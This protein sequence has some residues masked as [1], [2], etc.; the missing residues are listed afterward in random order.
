MTVEEKLLKISYTG[1]YVNILPSHI[2][3]LIKPQMELNIFNIKKLEREMVG[4]MRNERK[5]LS[6]MFRSMIPK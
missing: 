4:E 2:N 6:T 1:K 3:L 5:I